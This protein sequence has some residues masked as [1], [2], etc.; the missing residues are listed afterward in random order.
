VAQEKPRMRT[1][2]LEMHSEVLVFLY[3][4]AIIGVFKAPKN[5]MRT[6]LS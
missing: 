5:Q 2:R 4:A 1:D 3:N 6:V